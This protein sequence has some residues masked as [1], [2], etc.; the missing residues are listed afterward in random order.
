M[1]L[2]NTT[3]SENVANSSFAGGGGI[4]NAAALTLLNSTVAHNAALG[5]AG[6]ILNWA[7]LTLSNSIVA[8]N[9]A[10][11]ATDLLEFDL[12]PGSGIEIPYALSAS[13]SLI[14]SSAGNGLLN[15]TDNN[16]VG[17][18]GIDLLDAMLGP[19]ANNGGPTLTHA[20][21]PGSPAVDAALCDPT[22]GTDQRGV[23]RPQGLTCD[24]GA[25]ELEPTPPLFAFSGF[26]APVV[27]APSVNVAKAGRSIPIK[28]SLDGDQG[29]DILHGT[30]TSM[31]VACSLSP[32][33][34]TVAETTT[35]ETTTA[36]NS[37]LTYDA[38]T[39]QYSYVWKSDK[40]WAQSCRQF[41]LRLSDGSTHTALFQFTR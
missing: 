35:A 11:L 38:S 28:F 41:T 30:P 22:I 18:A 4:L 1:T 7:S 39:D 12:G 31:Q 29:L 3:V 19:L 25:F 34:S 2:T 14:G 36:G 23:S 8:G 15:F 21:L 27:S 33:A 16:L 37:T 10:Q 13:H 40:S 17:G 26:L 6:G 9:T 32:D 5:Q 20:L 24:M